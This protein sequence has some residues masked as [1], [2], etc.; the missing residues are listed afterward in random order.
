MKQIRAVA[1]GIILSLSAGL[2][3]A[4][5]LKVR[6]DHPEVYVVK[7]GDTLWD[8][9]ELFL[10]T[11]WLWPQLWQANP[12]VD[13]PHLIYPGDRLYLTFINGKPVL[14]KKPV[15]KLSPHI[16]PQPHKEAL[17][18]IP[19]AVL[20]PFL[21]R[22]QIIPMDEFEELPYVLG[23]NEGNTRS[24]DGQTL[25][26]K[27]KLSQPGYYGIYHP[28]QQIRR[29]GWGEVLGVRMSLV[30]K[31]QAVQQGKEL[32]AL[33]VMDGR[34]EI[35]QGSKLLPLSPTENQTLQ[36]IPMPPKEMIEGHIVASHHNTNYLAAHDVVIID[37][38]KRDGLKPGHTMAVF[39]QG[40]EVVD[41]EDNP[42]YLEDAGVFQKALGETTG[43]NTLQLPPM[44][45]GYVMVFRTFDDF[46]YALIMKSGQQ[47]MVKDQVKSLR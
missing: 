38:G 8:I 15:I 7:K 6:A 23:N 24:Y 34:R 33:K 44:S 32:I 9:S 22:E 21:E 37:R 1:L 13:N 25:Y 10:A 2:T 31:A 28:E 27:G 36:Y 45:H 5:E 35:R 46:S 3:A 4:D 20:E 19:Y 43:W 16:R 12:Q 29:Q 42:V 11:P 40:M 39:Q 41:N 47:M 17:S 18:V 30:A 14:V 26:A